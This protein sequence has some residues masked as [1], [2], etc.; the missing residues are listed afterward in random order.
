MGPTNGEIHRN[1]KT[2]FQSRG[3]KLLVTAFGSVENPATDKTDPAT[4][5]K[6]LARFVKDTKLDGVDVNFMDEKAFI[7]GTA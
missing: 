7:E 4:A 2:A 5:A 3:K 6:L 1:I